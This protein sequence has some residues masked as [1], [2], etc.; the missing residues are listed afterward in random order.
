[1]RIIIPDV[2]IGKLKEVD[3]YRTSLIG[4]LRNIIKLPEEK[5]YTKLTIYN[6]GKVLQFDG[7]MVYCSLIL[8]VTGQEIYSITS[9]VSDFAYTYIV[10][11]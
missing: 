4:E 3:T 8:E 2:D 1:M 10:L 11:E 5:E 6:R 7:Y 9:K